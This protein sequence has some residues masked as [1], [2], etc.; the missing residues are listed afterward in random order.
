[1]KKSLYFLVIVSLFAVTAKAQVT[2]GMQKSPERGAVLELKSDTLGFLPP[3]VDLVSTTLPKP[4]PVHVKGMVVYN[5]NT[6]NNDSLPAGLYVNTGVRWIYLSETNSPVHNWFYMPSIVFDTSTNGTFSRNLY[7]ECKAQ[8]NAASG[9]NL[10]VGSVATKPLTVIPDST[11][12]NYFVT[13]Y[14]SN[15][16]SNIAITPGGTMT[17]TIKNQASDSTLINIVFVEK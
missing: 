13:R 15:V 9:T 5:L 1:M 2:I 10:V 8:L 4:L 16:F 7:Q 3:R 17:Y 14:D 12:L 11:Q 6:A